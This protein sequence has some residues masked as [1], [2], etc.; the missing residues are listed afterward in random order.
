MDCS[1]PGSSIHGISQARILKWGTIFFLQGIFLTQG[2]NPHLL[3]W[4]ADSLPLSHQGSPLTSILLRQ[5]LNSIWVCFQR[6][7]GKP[8]TEGGSGRQRKSQDVVGNVKR[9]PIKLM[10]ADSRALG[11]PVPLGP[12]GWKPLRMCQNFLKQAHLG[13]TQGW[14]YSFSLLSGTGETTFHQF[15]QKQHTA[16]FPWLLVNSKRCI[17]CNLLCE[18]SRWWIRSSWRINASLG[19]VLNTIVGRNFTKITGLYVLGQNAS[20]Y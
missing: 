15:P 7:L 19:W 20:D 4:Q 18:V 8:D 2:L 3:H 11:P 10:P 6:H 12:S 13:D 16:S 14:S 5:E 9:E 17:F 1:L